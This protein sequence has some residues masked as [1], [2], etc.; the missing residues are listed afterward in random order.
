MMSVEKVLERNVASNDAGESE[1]TGQ[2]TDRTP[3]RM[4]LWVRD[5]ESWTDSVTYWSVDSC[6]IR[7]INERLVENK[8]LVLCKQRQ[9]RPGDTQ[10][11][12]A[13]HKDAAVKTTIQAVHAIYQLLWIYYS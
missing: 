10:Q 7:V 5:S 3:H 9:N 6:V 12:G 13:A 8:T 2:S 1:G 4:S 11:T